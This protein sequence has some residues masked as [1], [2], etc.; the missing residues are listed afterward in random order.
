M[1]VFPVGAAA[2]VTA[3]AEAFGKGQWS[4]PKT[5][6][7]DAQ[8]KGFNI[9]P[10]ETGHWGLWGSSLPRLSPVLSHAKHLLPS[11]EAFT[12]EGPLC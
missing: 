8:G 2:P 7:W 10:R 11:L 4:C 12:R 9:F 5:Q 1:L 6:E 3:S